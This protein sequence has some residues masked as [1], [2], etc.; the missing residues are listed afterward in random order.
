MTNAAWGIKRTCPKCNARFYDLN[1]MPVHCPR[2]GFDYDPAQMQ[3]ARRGRKKTTEDAV[4]KIAESRKVEAKKKLLKGD[5]DIDLDQFSDPG[6]GEVAGIEEIEEIDDVES[7]EEISEIE[8]MDDDGPSSEDDA[9][10]ESII[11][12]MDTGGKALI[13]DVEDEEPED[14]D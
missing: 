1:K 3:K 10:D 7:L 12:D 8:D 5:D 14:K 4:K 9:D 13:D 6:M 11:E 2:C